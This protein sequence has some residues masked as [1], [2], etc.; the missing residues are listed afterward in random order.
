MRNSF[1]HIQT[2]LA[3]KWFSHFVLPVAF[4]ALLL[5]TG[6]DT[7]E[8]VLKSDSLDYKKAKAISWYNKKEYAKAIPVLEELIGLMKGRESTEELYYMY[9][10]A[11]YKQGDFMI[12]A[13]HFKNFYDLYPNSSHAEEC[14]YM[15]CKSNQAQSPKPDLD[16]TYTYKALDAYTLFLNSYAD[17]KYIEECNT[18]VKELRRKL[19]KKALNAAELYYKTENY[20]AAATSYELILKD[21]PDIAESEKV[22][23]MI[24][25]S[26][27]KFAVNSI[28][29][30]K[31]ERFNNV[32][33]AYNDFK[34]KF[35]Q[36]K[37]LD[38]AAKAEQSSHFQAVVSSFEW[39]EMSNL[40]DRERYFRIFFKEAK[41]QRP[42]IKDEYQLAQVDKLTE[43]GYFLIVKTNFA[44]SEEKKSEERLPWLDQTVKTYFNFVDLF[45]K[46]R[47]SK[48]AERVYNSANEQITKIKN[49][50]T[51]PAADAKTERKGKKGK[52]AA[53]DT[54]NNGTI[55]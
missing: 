35:G 32:I 46:S 10:M 28:P 22:S 17:G 25:K 23:Y 26:N 21:F 54:Q 37:Y 19:E 11:N 14:L 53:N 41:L 15:W 12:S 7:P 45:P 27:Y 50:A 38:D 52:K 5:A 43:K 39:A 51:A 34:Y 36:S 55:N 4:C 31:A 20:R 33:K 48:E 16:Q 2:L 24:V 47:Y 40:I 9:A 44:L 6:C 49:K 18:A 42:F 8:K 13:Y 29:Q 30:K 1:N 3:R